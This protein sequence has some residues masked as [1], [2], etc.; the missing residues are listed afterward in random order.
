MKGGSYDAVI[1]GLSLIHI[2]SAASK[3][4]EAQYLQLL[5]QLGSEFYILRE[6]PLSD[7]SRAAGSYVA[8]GIRRLR[9]GEVEMCIRDRAKGQELVSD[10][11]WGEKEGYHLCVNTSG[12]SIKEI[13]PLIAEYAKHWLG[14]N[15]H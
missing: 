9:A 1:Y 6:A 13:T 11:K 2:F 3:K 4:V 7:V 14:E 5:E 15:G 8:E 12:L 10:F